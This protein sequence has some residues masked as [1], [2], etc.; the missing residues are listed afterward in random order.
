[1]IKFTAVLKPTDAGEPELLLGIILSYA[2]LNELRKGNPILFPF[3]EVNV[4]IPD[5][6]AGFP[7]GKV[8]IAADETEE[9]VL[10]QFRQR[11]VQIGE[12][13]D[14]KTPHEAQEWLKRQAR[15]S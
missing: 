3:S 5:G 12:L 1:M 4:N 11:G 15:E 8:M 7:A 2:N 10:E 14:T 9:A 6:I 13:V